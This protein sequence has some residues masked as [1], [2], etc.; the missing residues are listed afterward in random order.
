[1]FDPLNPNHLERGVIGAVMLDS[2]AL[3]QPEIRAL[4]P[5]HFRHYDGI[6]TVLLDLTAAGREPSL[7]EVAQSMSH[8]RWPKGVTVSD[9]IDFP[10]YATR[11]EDLAGAARGLLNA[12]RRQH[13]AHVAADLGRALSS[14]ETDPLTV[15]ASAHEALS[16]LI[17]T[18]PRDATVSIADD[19]QAAMDRILHPQRHRGLTSGLPSLDAVLGGWQPKTLNVL[20]ARPSMGKSALMGQLAQ[21]AAF[22]GPSQPAHALLFSL[23]D[24]ETVVRMR[25]LSRMSGVEINHEQAPHA[26]AA[27]RLSNAAAKLETIRDRW[28]IDPEGNLDAI[29]STCWQRHKEGRLGL[30]LIDQ[31]SHVLA[32]PS[33]QKAT[34]RNELYGYVT[35][36]LKREVAN[37]LGV[38][39]ILAHQL[40]RESAKRGA[41]PELTDLRDSGE[42]EQDADTVT[43]IH[44]WD[45]YDPTDRPGAAGLL[46]KKNRNG[47]TRDLVVQASMKTFKFWEARYE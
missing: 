16:D 3:R 24:P 39:V 5:Q 15:M 27:A 20:A 23:E 37:R 9:L 1:M 18:T 41:E 44:R 46:V 43:F 36:T 29:V 47:P 7:A 2:D 19:L 25:A 33:T 14:G 13:G 31:L 38:P 12:Y 45:Y 21:A 22:G 8:P 34:N 28:M 6:W 10:A 26:S 17:G 35:K 40:S 42:I 11:P 32:A 30:V 4:K